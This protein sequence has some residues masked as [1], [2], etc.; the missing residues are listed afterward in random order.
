VSEPR[1]V[2][3]LVSDIQTEALARMIGLLISDA[4]VAFQTRQ[5]EHGFEC[6]NVA[7]EMAEELLRRLREEVRG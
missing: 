3:C 6:L 4:I 5:D 1:K 7:A 2:L